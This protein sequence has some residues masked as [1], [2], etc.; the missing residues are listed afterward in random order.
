MYQ[1]SRRYLNRRTLGEEAKLM[2]RR[3]EDKLEGRLVTLRS[4]RRRCQ[5]N[6]DKTEAFHHLDLPYSQNYV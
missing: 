1:A 5:I 4:E 6:L 3:L 2:A